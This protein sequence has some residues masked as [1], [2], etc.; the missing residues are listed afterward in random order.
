MA[1]KTLKQKISEGLL[2]LDGAMG[3][4]LM[5][6]GIESGCN[7]MLNIESPQIVTDIHHSYFDAGSDG[8]YTN[9]FGANEITLARHNLADKAEQIN[10]AAVKIAKKVAGDRYVIGDIG[11]CGEFLKPLGTLE[12][13]KLKAAFARQAKALCGAGV[14]GF[15]IETF[16]AVDEA[17]VATEAVKSVCN[18]PVFVS[19]AFDQAGSD[20]RTMMGASVEMAVNE[21]SALGVDAL[22]FNCGTLKMEQYLQ[23]AEKFAKLLA[24]KKIALLAKPNGGKPELIDGKA[25]YKLSD[26]DFGD[27]LAKIHKAGAVLVGGCC[28]TT[29][30][31]IKAMTTKIKS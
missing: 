23:L 29:P 26:K 24:G 28:G 2:F 16:M 20:F 19:L 9:T 10:A 18:L 11:P 13:E 31:H 7:E 17:K 14:D 27:W 15:A 5:A 12:P 22:G 4:Q 8:V 1:K 3:T 21:F 30:N 6:R 25:V